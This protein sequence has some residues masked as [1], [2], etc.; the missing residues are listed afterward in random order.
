[1]KPPS[2]FGE[3][4]YPAEHQENNGRIFSVMNYENTK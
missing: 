1:M 3:L 2:G 4:F